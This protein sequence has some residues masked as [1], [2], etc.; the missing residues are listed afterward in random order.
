MDGYTHPDQKRDYPPLA[1]GMGAGRFRSSEDPRRSMGADRDPTRRSEAQSKTN[2]IGFFL[3]RSLDDSKFMVHQKQ[4]DMWGN[5]LIK[6]NFPPPGEVVDSP[7]GIN[8]RP[9]RKIESMGNNEDFFLKR[10]LVQPDMRHGNRFYEIMPES[11]RKEPLRQEDNANVKRFQEQSRQFYENY[12]FR[13]VY[14]SQQQKNNQKSF[15]PEM[16]STNIYG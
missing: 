8:S 6:R 16:K 3:D 5:P 9:G 15:Y 14:G 11:D 10:S 2:D 1:N 12:D 13:R 7:N 4:G